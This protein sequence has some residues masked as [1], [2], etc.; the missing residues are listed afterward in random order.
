MFYK[1]ITKSILLICLL[2]AMPLADARGQ[3]QGPAE[4]ID[5]MEQVMRGNSN[6]AE[7]TMR[8]ERPRYQREVSMRSWML[9]RDYSMIIITAPSRD[10]GTAF[11][12]R[13]N[14]IWNYDPRIDRTIRLPSSM[15]A[16]SWMGSDFTNDD[17]VR[18]S[19]TV[20]DFEH[21]IL[22]TG[23]YEG[24]NAWVI[25][26]IPKP[27]TPIVWGK[28]KMW[29]CTDTYVQLRV[30]NYDQQEELVNTMKLDEIRTM[31]DREIPTRITVIPAGKENEQTILVYE[32][33]EFDIDIDRRFFTQ[34][35]MQRQR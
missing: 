27:D 19:D 21:E 29:I 9:G 26:L 6:Y 31:N 4:I 34:Q 1:T 20:E 15:M 23:E 30:E 35:N 8:I 3:S 33:L 22:R 7:M 11:L 12:M 14:D 24:R 2:A 32:K 28:V 13:E 18:D 10:E 17:L 25:R 16:Q 5:R